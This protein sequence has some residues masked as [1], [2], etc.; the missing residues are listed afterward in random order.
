MSDQLKT[1]SMVSKMFS[2]LEDMSPDD[3]AS[4]AIEQRARFYKLMPGIIWPDDWDEL[5]YEVKKE[6][7]DKLDEVGLDESN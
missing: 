6:R 2:I 3:D 7:L 1:I 5:T 4:K